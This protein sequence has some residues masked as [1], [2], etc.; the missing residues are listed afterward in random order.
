MDACLFLLRLSQFNKLK[1][2]LYGLIAFL[3]V[4]HVPLLFL[5]VSQ[6]NPVTKAWDWVLTGACFSMQA[7]ETITIA[8][9]AISFLTDFA[10]AAFPAVLLRK[11]K[12]RTQRKV[13]LCILMGLGIIT[14]AVAI[15]ITAPRID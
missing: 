8:Q 7:V 13:A 15:A 11:L 6:C 12:I 4:T 10:C 2:V 3:F 1:N 14:A 9:G 5:I